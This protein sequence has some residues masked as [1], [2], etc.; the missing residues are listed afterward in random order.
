MSLL[1][2]VLLVDAA[3]SGAMGVLFLVA[4]GTLAPL[5]GLPVGLLA[6]VT[7]ILIPFAVLLGWLARRETVLRPVI[8]AVVAGNWLWVGASGA[9]LLS[10]SV[11]PTALGS[12]VVI[13]QA[14]AV[15]AFAALE[16]VGLR[17]SE[18]VAA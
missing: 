15:A 12:A 3:A 10:G 4:S 5:L 7:A 1:R 14:V 2:R 17:A 8:V 6:G 16:L 9:L 13:G 11:S 18:T